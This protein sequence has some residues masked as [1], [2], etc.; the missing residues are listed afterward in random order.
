M[1]NLDTRATLHVSIRS[2][3][4]LV[5]TVA[6]TCAFAIAPSTAH[7]VITPLAKIVAIVLFATTYMA[8]LASLANDLWEDPGI[9]FVAAMLGMFTF[10]Y[11]LSLLCLLAN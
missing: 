3:L 11:F 4:F 2:L 7:Q 1:R 9:N 10:P 8:T 6:F 5:M